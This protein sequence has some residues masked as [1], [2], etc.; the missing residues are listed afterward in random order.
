MGEENFHLECNELDRFLDKQLVVDVN[1]M[2]TETESEMRR[3]EDTESIDSSGFEQ[4]LSMFEKGQEIEFSRSE[5]YHQL[6]NEGILGN[7][8]ENVLYFECKENPDLIHL[9]AFIIKVLAESQAFADGN[10]RTAYVSGC[11]FLMSYQREK[12][13]ESPVIPLLDDEFVSLLQDVAVGKKDAESLEN[14]LK[15]IER[16]IRHKF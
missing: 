11:V 15:P 16:D 1:R 4:F 9:T 14:F 8:F 10:K 5:D 13:I 12:G 7:L 3:L 2:I 6:I